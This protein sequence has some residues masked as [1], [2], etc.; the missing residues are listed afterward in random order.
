MI[1][2][3]RI[4]FDISNYPIEVFARKAFVFVTYFENKNGLGNSSG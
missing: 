1:G 3:R 4:G 2:F